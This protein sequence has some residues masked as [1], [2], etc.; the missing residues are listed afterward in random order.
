MIPDTEIVVFQ[1]CIDLH[2]TSHFI[3]NQIDI[4]HYCMQYQKLSILFTKPLCPNVMKMSVLC[5]YKYL[6]LNI[7]LSFISFIL[8]VTW[9]TYLDMILFKIRLNASI[10]VVKYYKR[11]ATIAY[12]E[13]M[14]KSYSSCTYLYHSWHQCNQVYTHKGIHWSGP[15]NFHV[16][17]ENFHTRL[18]LK[19]ENHT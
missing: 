13:F 6:S 11:Y 10:F 12:K 16:H 2:V 18:Y 14:Q 15:Y 1:I 19:I 9:K 4:I 17:R 5:T 7:L 3:A 8:V